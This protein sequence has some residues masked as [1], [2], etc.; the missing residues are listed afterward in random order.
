MKKILLVEDD[1]W[2]AES[3]AKLLQTGGYKVYMADNAEDAMRYVEDKPVDLLIA[4]ILLGDQ[5]SLSL[6]HELQ[7]HD[8]TKTIPV[9]VCSALNHEAMQLDHLRRYGVVAVLD[10]AVLLPEDLLAQVDGQLE[11]R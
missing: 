2:L 9:I 7:S 5:N 11:D 6:L 8:D 10:K 1:H 4:D 3:Y